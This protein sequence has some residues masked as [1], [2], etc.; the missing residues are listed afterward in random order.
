MPSIVVEESE[1][2]NLPASRP[3]LPSLDLTQIR[4]T[5]G[6]YSPT[7]P[8]SRGQSRLHALY[9]QQSDAEDEEGSLVRTWS[10]IGAPGS[11]IATSE[12]NTEL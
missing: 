11:Q 10:N 3:P 6:G 2:S 7:S 9:S 12:V 5:G 1:T 4:N 8:T